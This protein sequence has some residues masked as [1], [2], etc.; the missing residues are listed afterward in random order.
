MM[1]ETFYGRDPLVQQ[2]LPPQ[3]YMADQ[4]AFIRQIEVE[5]VGIIL[6]NLPPHVMQDGTGYEQISPELIRVHLLDYKA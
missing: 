3:T 1:K 5:T 6:L 2:F 4:F